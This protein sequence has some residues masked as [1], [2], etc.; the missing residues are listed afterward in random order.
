MWRG[1]VP[2]EHEFTELNLGKGFWGSGLI[3]SSGL[4]AVEVRST[5]HRINILIF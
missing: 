4:E 1:S 3:G 5:K 2:D